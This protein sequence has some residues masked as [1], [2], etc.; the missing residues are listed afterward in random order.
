V[1]SGDPIA[2]GLAVGDMVSVYTTSGATVATCIIRI[3]SR[4]TNSF[5]GVVVSGSAASVSAS[6]GAATARVGGALAGPTG[7]SQFPLNFIA[8]THVDASNNPTRVNFQNSTP[9][10]VTAGAN[11][12]L[13]GP[14]RFEGY[15]TNPGDGGVALFDGDSANPS[16][17][18]TV[19]TLSGSGCVLRHLAWD[20]NGGI[21]AGQAVGNNAMV[22]V[23][24]TSTSVERCRFTNAYRTGLR[25]AG[26]GS[27][28]T[29][30]ELRDNQ[31]DDASG[32]GNL[33]I[34]EECTVTRTMSHYTG[35]PGTDSAC[36]VFSS[37]STEPV[38]VLF[39]IAKNAGGHSFEAT[40]NH[41]SIRIQN[42]DS[43]DP[44]QSGFHA[45]A[46]AATSSM[47]W[48]E[49]NIFTG[50]V[51]G[52]SAQNAGQRTGPRM[53]NNAFHG[54]SSGQVEGDVNTS[55]V[56]GSI[57][58][59]GDPFRSKSTGDFRLTE[60]ASA[61]CHAS[62]R[63]EFFIDTGALADAAQNSNPAYVGICVG[64]VQ[65]KALGIKPTAVALW[66]NTKSPNR[67]LTA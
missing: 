54:Q 25:M 20:G 6:A 55:F 52:V 34:T 49:N 15:G 16:A 9:Y 21:S 33:T 46:A 29:E 8:A 30:C 27:H 48:L 36:Y 13:A 32:F 67:T 37:D 60:T 62:G 22:D 19:F 44:V 26:G 24:G 39:S 59:P 2:D 1:A 40:G 50:G 61:E 3:T 65:P 56:S 5:Q 7:S 53:Q 11:H 4:T 64:A 41:N 17:P 47:V 23:T 31:R 28:V 63:S 18:Y 66:D 42:C 35:S 45:A 57:T 58:L 38:A 12:T 51:W 14:V 10:Q 43:I